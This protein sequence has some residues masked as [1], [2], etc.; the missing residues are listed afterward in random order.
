MAHPNKLFDVNDFVAFKD[1]EKNLL[2]QLELIYEKEKN[3]SDD[4]LE[5]LY[6]IYKS[7]L[8]EALNQIDKQN[9]QNEQNA[10]TGKPQPLDQNLATCIV[11]ESQPPRVIY[12]VKG[13]IGIN[14]YLFESLKFCSCS[15]FKFNVLSKNE[16]IYCKHIIIVKLLKAMNK[17][18]LKHV[19][20]TDLVELIKQIH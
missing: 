11:S 8:L 20:D 17:I 19:K 16:Y 6:F 18:N 2:E 9:E 14:Y 15:S 10:K 4:L 7:P 3:I 13:S 12:Q 1:L 5:S